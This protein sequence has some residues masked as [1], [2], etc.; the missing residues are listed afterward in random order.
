VNHDLP[1][2]VTDP[3]MNRFFMTIPQAAGFVIEAA[4]LATDSG[5]T[6]MLDMGES[7]RILDLVSRYAELRHLPAPAIVVTGMRH[8][9]KISEELAAPGEERAHT[10][11]EAIYQLKVPA[12]A[13]TCLQDTERLCEAAYKGDDDL[14]ERLSA[15]ISEIVPS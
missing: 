14:A 13:H 4:V 2:T 6:F 7:Y 12:P 5:A 10:A 11:N 15:F 8:G 3:D 9:E 1:V